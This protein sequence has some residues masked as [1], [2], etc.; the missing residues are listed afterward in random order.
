MLIEFFRS[1]DCIVFSFRRAAK[2][3]GP[4][5]VEAPESSTDVDDENNLDDSFSD[6]D[7]NEDE[8]HEDDHPK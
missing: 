4:G 2:K 8:I 1:H 6:D 5:D 7:S 3:Y